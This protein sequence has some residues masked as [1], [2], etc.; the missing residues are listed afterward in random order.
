MAE[1]AKWP[2]YLDLPYI[3]TLKRMKSE[4]EAHLKTRCDWFVVKKARI[5]EFF[6]IK[7]CVRFEL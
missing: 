3:F 1:L 4:V 5:S 7:K 2:I 6:R